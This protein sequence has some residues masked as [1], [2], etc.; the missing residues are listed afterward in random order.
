M[1]TQGLAVALGV[2]AIWSSRRRTP[3]RAQQTASGRPNPE[4][5]RVRCAA[6]SA[7]EVIGA[8]GAPRTTGVAELLA[9]TATCRRSTFRQRRGQS[10]RKRFHPDSRAMVGGRRGQMR[11]EIEDSHVQSRQGSLVQVPKADDIPWK[12]FRPAEPALR[13]EYRRRK[14]LYPPEC[15]APA[16]AGINWVSITLNRTPAPYDNGNQPQ[17]SLRG[18]ETRIHRRA[19]VETTR[20]RRT[21]STGDEKTCRRA[22]PPISAIFTRTALSLARDGGHSSPS[23]SNVFVAR[24]RWPTCRL[25]LPSSRDSMGGPSAGSRSRGS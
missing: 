13:C 17:S 10:S 18:C 21:S 25:H 5:C 20:S 24:R 12:R 22:S 23:R 9:T 14:T 1:K 16:L 4:S 11:V 7:R 19:V 2:V 3:V 8:Q 6:A 15:A